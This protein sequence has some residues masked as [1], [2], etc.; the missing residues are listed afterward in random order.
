MEIFKGR[1]FLDNT[2]RLQRGYKT[3]INNEISLYLRARIVMRCAGAQGLRFHEAEPASL[4]PESVVVRRASVAPPFVFPV[5]CSERGIH[6]K[7]VKGV[8]RMP[9]L[10]QATKDAVSCEN[11]RVPANG[12]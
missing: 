4:R 11:V 9:W 2:E 8:R 1:T 7:R 12:A 6:E 10:P 5:I 3:E